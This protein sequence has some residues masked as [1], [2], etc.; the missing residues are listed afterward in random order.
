MGLGRGSLI[1]VSLPGDIGK[2]RPALIVQTG[3][4][5]TSKAVVVL[6]LTSKTDGPE[7]PRVTLQPSA[8]NGLRQSS[9]VMVDK[10]SLI[11]RDKIGAEFGRLGPAE[12]VL[13]NRAMAHFLGIG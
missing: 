12:M 6:P 7:G 3:D 8:Q 13:V 2:P 5:P 10:P 11:R 4:Y 1:V 9:R